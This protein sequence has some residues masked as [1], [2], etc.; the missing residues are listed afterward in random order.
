MS[1]RVELFHLGQLVASDKSQ[2]DRGFRSVAP[3]DYLVIA[4][5][6]GVGTREA[7]HVASGET[8]EVNFGRSIRGPAPT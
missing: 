7:V 4:K 1:G 5:F 6:G 8:V 3:G 2:S